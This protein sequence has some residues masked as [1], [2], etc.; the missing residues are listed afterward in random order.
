MLLSLSHFPILSFH[1]ALCRVIPLVLL[2]PY[3][4]GFTI[5]I[6]DIVSITQEKQVGTPMINSGF[7]YV[8]SLCQNLFYW[9]T[10]KWPMFAHPFEPMQWPWNN[11]EIPCE[12]F[13]STVQNRFVQVSSSWPPRCFYIINTV[14]S[15]LLPYPC[16]VRFTLVV[17]IPITATCQNSL[18]MENLSFFQDV[19]LRSPLLFFLSCKFEIK[20]CVLKSAVAQIWRAIDNVPIYGFPEM[21]LFVSQVSI[22]VGWPTTRS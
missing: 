22:L 2:R 5:Q 19:W 13:A 6:W 15:P 16:F 3:I 8:E 7:V 1:F 11:I 12:R 9:M 10:C 14:C 18:F 20:F 17:R 4:Y 21:P